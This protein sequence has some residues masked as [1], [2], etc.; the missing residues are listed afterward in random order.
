[1][2]L[3]YHHLIHRPLPR[4]I[5]RPDDTRSSLYSPLALTLDEE[6]MSSSQ[7]HHTTDDDNNNNDN[8]E[9]EIKLS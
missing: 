5:T 6:A 4:N 2:K 8:E 7:Y 3:D 1:M 9:S